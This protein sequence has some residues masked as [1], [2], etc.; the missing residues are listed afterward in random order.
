[1]TDPTIIVAAAL[2]LI[3]NTLAVLGVAWAGGRLLGKLEKAV[4]VL[5]EE[6]RL[7]RID[8]IDQGKVMERV[9]TSLDALEQRVEHLERVNERRH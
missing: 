6:V 9:V 3:V 8:R 7:S 5:G 1:M 2:G 4:E